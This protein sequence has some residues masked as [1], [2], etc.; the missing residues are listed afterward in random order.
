MEAPKKIEPNEGLN[1]TQ[2]RPTK[3]RWV[4][5]TRYF[6]AWDSKVDQQLNELGEDGWEAVGISAS[7]NMAGMTLQIHVLLKKP[8]VYVPPKPDPD[9]EAGLRLKELMKKRGE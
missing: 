1:E 6:S 2:E 8:W 9:N 4:Y 3:G 5:K 7:S